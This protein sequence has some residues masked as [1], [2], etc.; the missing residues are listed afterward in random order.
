MNSTWP[1]VLGVSKPVSRFHLSHAPGRD[2]QS[3]HKIPTAEI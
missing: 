3:G 1:L 2:A